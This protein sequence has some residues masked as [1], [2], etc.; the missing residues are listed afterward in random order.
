[1]KMDSEE[2]SLLMIHEISESLRILPEA[3]E[4]AR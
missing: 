2:V 3:F 1:M 4:F